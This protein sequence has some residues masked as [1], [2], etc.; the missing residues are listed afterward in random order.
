MKL[1]IHGLRRGKT[2]FVFGEPIYRS[3]ILKPETS[4]NDQHASFLL[5]RKSGTL[6]S[7]RYSSN[8]EK[9]N[10]HFIENI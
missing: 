7:S 2:D 3:F 5:E 10:F 1:V 6:S 9:A 4:P 8:S